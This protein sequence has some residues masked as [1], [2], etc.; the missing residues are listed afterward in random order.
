MVKCVLFGKSNCMGCK[1]AE[2]F[3]KKHNIEYWY[4][5]IDDEENRKLFLSLGYLSVPVLEYQGES[6]IGFD[7]DRYNE[8]FE[9]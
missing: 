5:S 4:V 2:T 7:E 6:V 8:V 3:L 1:K 9:L